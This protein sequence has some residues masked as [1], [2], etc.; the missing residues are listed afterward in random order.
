MKLTTVEA[1]TEAF[2]THFYMHHGLPLAITSDRGSQF[3]SGFWG[4]VCERLSIHR[5]LSTA[6][7]PQTDGATERANQEVERILRVFT[8]YTQDNWSSL[9]PIVA[10]A[11]NNRDASATGLSPFF[12]THG[13]HIDP[14]SLDDSGTLREALL[15]PERAGETFVK[16]LRDATEWAQA[17]IAIAQERQQEHANRSRQAAPVYRQGDKVWL[18][19]RNIRTD[20]ASKKLDWLHAQYKVLEVPSP[21]TVRLDVLGGVHPVFHVDLIRP[22]ASDPFP[23]QIMD[24]SQPPPIRVDGEWEYQVEEILA[25]RTRKIGRGKRRE[26][27]VKWVGYAETS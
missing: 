2:L 7:H 27:L 19:L 18:N 20:R 1:L 23:S 26:A 24:D 6:F 13:Y 14:I 22:A 12:F 21:H 15:P 3:V 5:R 9:L 10:A 16:R 4:R 17:A 25:A 11:I 8:S